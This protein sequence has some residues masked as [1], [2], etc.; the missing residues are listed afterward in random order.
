MENCK[1][2][3]IIVINI[4]NHTFNKDHTFNKEYLDVINASALTCFGPSVPNN[5]CVE[6]DAPRKNSCSLAGVSCCF[7][8]SDSSWL[9]VIE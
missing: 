7:S 9:T 5:P 8:A 4:F 1:L 6:V 2:H 3:I